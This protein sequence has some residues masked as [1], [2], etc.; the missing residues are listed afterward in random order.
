MKI[1]ILTC[2]FHASIFVF[3]SQFLQ[4]QVFHDTSFRQTAYRGIDY[5]YNMKFEQA[6]DVFESLKKSY[7]DHPA[8]YFLLAL[9]RW[10]Q[11][12]VASEMTEYHSFIERHLDKAITLNEQYEDQPEYRL[13]YTFFQYMN[14]AFKARYYT[15]RKEWW[16][17]AMAGRKAFPYLKKGFEY[18]KESREFYFGSG[19]YHYYAEDYPK[20]HPIVQPLMIFFPKGSISRGIAELEQASAR[21]NFTQFEAM[22]YL[23]DIY[24]KQ[25]KTGLGLKLYRKLYEQFPQNTWFQM[26]YG[27]ALIAHGN[28]AEAKGILQPLIERYEEIEGHDQQNIVTT[29]SRYTTYLMSRVYLWYGLAL[30]DSDLR[31]AHKSL[32]KAENMVRLA[33]LDQDDEYRPAIAYARGICDDRLKQREQAVEHY[34]EVLSLDQNHPY[35][36]RAKDC[37]DEPCQQVKVSLLGGT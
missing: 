22:F 6:H 17:A 34:R 32:E 26:E 1:K 36:Q 25:G 2:L 19:I 9:N 28:D 10:W 20:T 3:S 35:K 11:T 14:Y 16:N 27:R 23:G 4:A 15:L 13:E 31:G 21:P 33:Q 29:E 5:T 7:T 37:I 8:P 18:Q 12:Y 24:L 30:L